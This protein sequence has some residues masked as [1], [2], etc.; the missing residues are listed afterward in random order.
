MESGYS[1]A[2]GETGAKAEAG[3]SLRRA[4]GQHGAD[5]AAPECEVGEM[6]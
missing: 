5:E 1:Q 6:V 3:L 4:G 2:Q